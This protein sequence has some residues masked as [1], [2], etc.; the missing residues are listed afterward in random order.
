MMA[1]GRKKR[2][3]AEDMGFSQEAVQR[4]RVRLTPVDVQQ[5][6]FRLAFRG[7]NEQDVDH[8]LDDVTEDLAA[9]HEENKRLREELELRGPGAGTEDARRHAEEIIRRAR[10]EAAR[11]AAETP[12]TG[13]AATAAAATPA[14]LVREREFLQRLASLVQEHASSLKDEAR[15]ARA[16]AE[17]REP[18]PEEIEEA[19]PEEIAEARPEE[20]AEPE[21]E[22]VLDRTAP[23]ASPGE[24]GDWSNPFE[25]PRES[26]DEE[27][28]S[29]EEPSLR[30]LFWGEE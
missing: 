16:A 18:E 5:K 19:Q 17:T 21:A 7:Y 30:E 8:F 22:P 20:R 13:A 27:G 2:Q 10:E 25:E 1:F 23:M 6:V 11:I 24:E 3:A 15:R 4:E 29:E 9:L 28:S 12:A 14:F 26:V